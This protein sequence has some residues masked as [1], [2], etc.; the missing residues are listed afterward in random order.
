MLTF[1]I[2]AHL[3]LKYWKRINF[4]SFLSIPA[5]LHWIISIFWYIICCRFLIIVDLWLNSTFWGSVFGIFQ[6]F[7]VLFF[8]K[9]KVVCSARQ[10][11]QSISKILQSLT[12]RQKN[13][14]FFF[15]C[16]LYIVFRS[17][18]CLP[19]LKKSPNP[20]ILN[21]SPPLNMFPFWFKDHVAYTMAKYGMSMCVLGMSAEFKDDGIAVN[22]LWPKTGTIISLFFLFNSKCFLS[23]CL[24]H[25]Y[26]I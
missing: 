6:V 16:S 11:F 17:K 8:K 20:H 3:V 12:G 7:L 2:S 1:W 10:I 5:D 22:A 4:R 24:I 15:H 9:T 18:V 25:Y 13:D 19:Y 21:I 26:F 14:F 23:K